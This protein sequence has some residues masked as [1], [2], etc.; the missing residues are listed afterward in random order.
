MKKKR[1]I[2]YDISKILSKKCRWNFIIGMRSNGKSFEVKY[3]AISRAYKEGKKIAY[4]R[5]WDTDIK[6]AAVD[7]YFDDMRKAS[8]GYMAIDDITNGEWEG[9]SAY[10][11]YLYFY[12]YDDNGKMIRSKNDIG[13]YLAV[14]MSEHYKSQTFIGYGTLVYEEVLTNKVYVT[15]EPHALM[16]LVSTI[17]RDEDA[18]VR[19]YLVANT[20][21][22]VSPYIS[23]WGLNNI[24]NQKPDTI[25]VYHLTREDGSVVDFAVQNTE[26]IETK[27]KLFFGNSQKQIQGGEWETKELPK[28]EKPLGYYELIYD[29]LIDY[30]NFKFRLML[31]GDGAN[32]GLTVYIYPYT[33]GKKKFQRIVTDKYSTSPFVTPYIDPKF[34]KAEKLIIE[35]FR[36]G[37]VAFSDNLTGSDFNGLVSNYRMGV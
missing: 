25:D 28:L 20:I 17:F 27:S 4:V 37:K 36:K 14:N 23:E 30:D 24:P 32:G 2:K 13:R 15:D 1:K 29:M 34:S 33:K 7:S 12:R 6:T 9:I 5:R 19:I 35:C 26:V 16:N 3:D 10:R 18:D 31:L 11:G 21:S 22:R 8:N